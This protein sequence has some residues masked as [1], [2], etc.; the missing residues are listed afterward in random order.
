AIKEHRLTLPILDQI[1]IGYASI[2]VTLS[3]E[4]E[5][6]LEYDFENSAFRLREEDAEVELSLEEARKRKDLTIIQAD[7]NTFA[8]ASEDS[9]IEIVYTNALNKA[10]IEKYYHY[11]SHLGELIYLGVDKQEKPL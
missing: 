11:I 8:V 7:D 5:E 1:V 4:P 2:G 6:E 10:K 3:N 9:D